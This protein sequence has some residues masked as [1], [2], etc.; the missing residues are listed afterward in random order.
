LAPVHA[1]MGEMM[2]EVDDAL[3]HDFLLVDLHR[4]FE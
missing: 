3:I 2:I 1:A 4:R